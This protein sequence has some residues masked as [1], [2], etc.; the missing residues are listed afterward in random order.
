MNS[1]KYIKYFLKV[2]KQNSFKNKTH[3]KTKKRH[4]TKTK[5]RNTTN[6]QFYKGTK[7]SR[8]ENNYKGGV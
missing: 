8:G 1:N 7:G 2:K 6:S 4:H 5:K 3:S